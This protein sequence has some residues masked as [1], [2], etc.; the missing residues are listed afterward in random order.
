[1]QFRKDPY[2]SNQKGFSTLELMVVLAIIGL[3]TAIAI[4]QYEHFTTKA[5][6]AEQILL[7][8]SLEKKMTV[9]F[10]FNDQYGNFDETLGEVIDP[11]YA[12]PGGDPDPGDGDGDG[13]EDGGFDS[14]FV[15]YHQNKW[16]IDLSLDAPKEA[17]ITITPLIIAN[18]L[19]HVRFVQLQNGQTL[20]KGAVPISPP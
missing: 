5:E 3:L 8:D 12:D 19:S 18:H 2:L 7:L 9:Y 20:Q 15:R 16:R 4:P 14:R 1:M 10:A 6:E 13:D 17:T 11:S